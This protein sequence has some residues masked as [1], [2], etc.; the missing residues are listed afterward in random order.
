MNERPSPVN[1]SQ[2]Y[3]NRWLF[4]GPLFQG[5]EELRAMGD[6]GLR[7]TVRTLESPGALVDCAGQL[8]VFWIMAALRTDRYALPGGVESVEFFGPQPIAVK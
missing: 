5:I 6:D 4:H 8:M 2:L 1:A 3:E 7:G